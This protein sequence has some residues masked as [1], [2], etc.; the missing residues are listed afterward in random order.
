MVAIIASGNVIGV[1]QTLQ[2]MGFDP[3]R[4]QLIA[5]LVF[6]AVAAAAG[7]LASGRQRVPA[8]LGL[9]TAA[10]LFGQTFVTETS[11]ALSSSGAAGSFDATGWLLTLLTLVAAGLVCGWAGA[12]LAADLRP[13]L[14]GT[15][16]ALA[17]AVRGLRIEG[18]ALSRLAVLVLA[19][20]VVA[21]ATP[22]F[23]AM[24]NF[25]PDSLMLRGAP[26]QV[27]LTGPAVVP[28][29]ASPGATAAP[30][31]GAPTF[32]PTTTGGFASNARP[33]LAW[34]PSGSGKVVQTYLP[35]PWTGGTS[36]RIE[37]D[38]YTP[39][40]YAHSGDRR[41]PSLYE[42]PWAYRWWDGGAHVATALDSLIDS[43]AMPAAIVVFVDSGGGP[44]PDT[45]CANTADG[46]QWFDTFAGGTL[47]RWVDAHYRTMADPSARA[48]MGMSVGGYCAA[49]LVVRHPDVF[50]TAISF[51]GYYQAGL[52]GTTAA[53]LFDNN[54]ALLA[55]ASPDVVAGRLPPSERASVGFIL[56]AQPSQP[57]Y[58]PQAT[59]FAQAL[60]VDG[61]PYVAIAAVQPHGWG[62]VRAHLA[63]ALTDWAR[64]LAGTGV[65]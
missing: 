13:P 38:V 6:G 1:N 41:Y 36:S 60:S 26:P 2:L 53:R 39:P 65:V 15:I 37:V 49:T 30:D 43:G 22:T 51:S 46:R 59:A 45:E 54:P 27:G 19:A 23:G 3:D 40:G 42:F 33:W 48:I 24:V 9:L 25:S 7:T 28:P 34:L 44:Y 29:A 17:A 52:F 11:A 5:A 63:E 47:V 58:G 50:Q 31:A 64:R 35:A 61:Y 56:V 62:Q 10:A 21:T 4:A 57:L 12:A 55:A 32:P 14:A 8:I 18:R 20:L 16:G